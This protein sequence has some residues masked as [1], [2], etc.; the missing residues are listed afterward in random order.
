MSVGTLDRQNDVTAGNP[1]SD[2][3]IE[4]PEDRKSHVS[5]WRR[6]IL[7]A[8]GRWQDDFDRMEDDIKFAE[9]IQW[10]GQKDVNSE[11][12][13]IANFTQR[14]VQMR[15]AA[16]YARNP[17]VAAKRRRTLDFAL[18]D[19]DSTDMVQSVQATMQ[20]AAMG[21][22][23]P[24]EALP[25]IADF[26]QGMER[27]RILNKLAKTL[28][29]VFDY[30]FN[31]QIPVMKRQM[32]RLVTRV[33]TTGVGYLKLGYS[34][35][36][37]MR[38]DD[39]DKVTD[40]RERIARIERMLEESDK[41]E[42]EEHSAE[43]SMLKTELSSLESQ[44]NMVVREGVIYDF[45]RST[46]IIP[47]PKC[48]CLEGFLGADWVA[49]EFVL[50]PDRIKEIWDVDVHAGS[51]IEVKQDMQD[52]TSGRPENPSKPKER[53]EIPVWEIYDKASGLMYTVADGY[54]D[55][56][57]EPREPSVRVEGFWPIFPLVF[58]AI[59]SEDTIFAPS[60]V[61][62]VKPMQRDLN[63]T[64]QALKNHR[65]ANQ[66]KYAAVHG[67]LS[68]EDKDALVENVPHSII[69]ISAL[70]GGQKVDD[71]IMPF[72]QHGIDPNMYDSTF[73]L[74]DVMRVTGAQEA[75]LGGTSNATATESSIA[76]TSRIS[77]LQSSSDDL[78]DFLTTVCHAT[79]QVMLLEYDEMTVKEIAGPGAVWPQL[80][81]Q[82]IARDLQVEV[83][84]GSSGRP[85][86]AMEIANFER[87]APFL[88]Q[89]PG[90]SPEWL[91]RQ[92]IKRLDDTLDLTEALAAGLPSILS[93]NAA[94][95]S[96]GAGGADSPEAQG[97]QGG[98]NA[99][100]APQAGNSQDTVS[101]QA[102]SGI[103]SGGALAVQP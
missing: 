39:V 78:D 88:I 58:N 17:K 8:K 11:E 40:I 63:S 12:R 19:E 18:Y 54:S 92:A 66:P 93:M 16:L 52:D 61:R 27:R 65:V 37:E 4:V 90:L 36:F 102:S 60:D 7:Y 50:S 55:F 38:P 69:E 75:N 87:L 44:Q 94:R 83:R 33:L 101:P 68:D 26:Q 85:N 10:K 73:L 82:E 9:G 25:L 84:A 53:T 32:K 48:T 23:V 41:G 47:D 21:G 46:S 34:R 15:T 51:S 96:N 76:E 30:T 81:P 74:D 14:H 5:E 62:L 91:V 100:A 20:A 103:P 89:M 24:D 71:V 64:R 86:K 31:E 35:A 49:Q 72:R 99:P 57:E 77:S 70:Q 2:E 13:Y 28:E 6:R 98:G 97:G 3:V 1:S 95:P 42:I 43:L 80:T 22:M 29:I 45:P 67:A 59:E 56:L 79:A